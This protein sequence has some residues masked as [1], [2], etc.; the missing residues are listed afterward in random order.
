MDNYYDISYTS[1]EDFDDMIA[2]CMAH[3]RQKRIDVI[4]RWLTSINYSGVVGYDIR[5][6]PN[7]ACIYTTDPGILIGKKGVNVETLK[8]MLSDEFYGD[9]E[10]K[11]TEVRDGFVINTANEQKEPVKKPIT[12]KK[13][14][15]QWF[16]G[17][18]LCIYG[19]LVCSTGYVAWVNFISLIHSD[20]VWKILLFSGGFI[21]DLALFIFFP[22]IFFKQLSPAINKK[23]K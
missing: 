15:Q 23:W 4:T 22:W 17:I 10:I 20:S 8:K 16:I 21:F 12:F 7:I 9:W 11:F 19:A 13:I 6:Y 18:I 2:E 1:T 14:V 5:M 3:G